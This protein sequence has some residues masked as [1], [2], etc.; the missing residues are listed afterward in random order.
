MKPPELIARCIR[1][2]SRLGQSVLDPFAGSG[3]TLIAAEQTGRVCYAM[4]ISEKYV[5]VSLQRWADATGKT[6]VLALMG[7]RRLRTLH[8]PGS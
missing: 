8:I 2:S 4:E 1:N 5:A 3:S 7:K 6:P